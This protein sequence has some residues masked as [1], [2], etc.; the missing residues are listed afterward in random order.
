MKD[1]GI[2]KDGMISWKINEGL[3]IKMKDSNI[4]NVN[5][6]RNLL[7]KIAPELKKKLFTSEELMRDYS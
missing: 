3:V 5:K 6:T 7:L 2:K 4:G 1:F